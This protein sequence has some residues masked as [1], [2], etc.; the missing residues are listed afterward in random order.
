MV[1]KSYR[2]FAAPGVTVFDV[3][4]EVVELGIKQALVLN[5]GLIGVKER[6]GWKE[7]RIS[8][9]V[10]NAT[11]RKKPSVTHAL[12]TKLGWLMMSEPDHGPS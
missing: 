5:K 11:A 3:R 6:K 9:Q 4:R 2:W 1:K 7:V 10:I 12:V 8:I